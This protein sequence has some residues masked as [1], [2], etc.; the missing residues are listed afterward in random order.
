[1]VFFS[2]RC[3]Y[4]YVYILTY[5]DCV[6]ARAGANRPTHTHTHTQ[7]HAHNNT[8][9]HSPTSTYSQWCTNWELS[10]IRRWQVVA[11]SRNS[12][13]GGVPQMMAAVSTWPCVAL[14]VCVQHLS[15]CLSVCVQHLS[16]WFVCRLSST[17]SARRPAQQVQASGHC[18]G[19]EW[20]W[21][22]VRPQ[23]CLWSFGPR[24][25]PEE[26]G[27]SCLSSNNDMITTQSTIICLLLLWNSNLAL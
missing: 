6:H 10:I 15:P 11:A 7:T 9:T 22:G 16:P 17:I 12:P 27:K 13:G 23:E 20:R 14:F 5:S 18:R 2:P 25:L 4:H 24:R 26:R 19:R 8:R 1:M 21:R 3:F